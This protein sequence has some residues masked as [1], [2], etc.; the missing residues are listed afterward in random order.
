[1][2]SGSSIGV[3]RDVGGDAPRLITRLQLGRCPSPRLLV[4]LACFFDW[5]PYL[6]PGE[7]ATIIMDMRRFLRRCWNAPG[8]GSG[9]R[10]NPTPQGITTMKSV[11]FPVSAL[12]S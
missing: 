2:P 9:S 12:N 1:M 7:I 5:R 8:P 3:R 11:S 4:F 10:E 6:G